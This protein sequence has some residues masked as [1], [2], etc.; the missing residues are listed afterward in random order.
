MY[1]LYG[2]YKGANYGFIWFKYG[3]YGAFLYCSIQYIH[4]VGVLVNPDKQSGTL[5]VRI[6]V[7]HSPEP[8]SLSFT[9]YPGG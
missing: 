8:Y 5:E 3:K 2:L 1:T 6:N 9:S 4:K 7:A